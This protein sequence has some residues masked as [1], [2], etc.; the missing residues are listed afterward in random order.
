MDKGDIGLLEN[1]PQSPT[2]FLDFRITD[3]N[4]TDN[5]VL[6]PQEEVKNEEKYVTIEKDHC[7]TSSEIFQDI[8]LNTKDNFVNDASAN[9]SNNTQIQEYKIE[10]TS[11]NNSKEIFTGST[12]SINLPNDYMS[13]NTKNIE[14]R[15]F[16][17]VTKPSKSTPEQTEVYNNGYGILRKTLQQSTVSLGTY[18]NQLKQ[19]TMSEVGEINEAVGKANEV[20]TDSFSSLKSKLQPIPSASSPE[21]S[22]VYTERTLTGYKQKLSTRRDKLLQEQQTI[23]ILSRAQLMKRLFKRDSEIIAMSEQL[24]ALQEKSI[25]KNGTRKEHNNERQVL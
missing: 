23:K 11:S 13:S 18:W 16:N 21:S 25:K 9:E 7:K 4:T 10:D 19:F 3:L 22:K 20:F 24:L 17:Y 15:K 8:K 12:P 6:I 2:S 1:A 5:N 14:T